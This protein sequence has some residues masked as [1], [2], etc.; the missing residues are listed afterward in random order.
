MAPRGEW[1][2]FNWIVAAG[3][4]AA[5]ISAVVGV[6]VFL[7]PGSPSPSPHKTGRS[8][9]PHKTGPSLAPAPVSTG[10]PPSFIDRFQIAGQEGGV[11][12]AGAVHIGQTLYRHAVTFPYEATSMFTPMIATLALPGRYAVFRALVGFD[13][14][15][16][17]GTTESMGVKVFAGDYAVV[18]TVV[19][20]NSPPCTI[21]G[22]I[23][24]ASMIK[25]ETYPKNNGARATTAFADP[26]VVNES[27]F[28]HMPTAAPC[29]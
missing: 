15:A 9:T 16:T 13:P 6:A 25:L 4:I 27:D 20:P 17:K 8:T 21:E 2:P 29:P 18:N 23:T 19:S 10:T 3:A 28:P 24:G 7:V 11:V 1:T 22:S 5:V 12:E 26:R 14:N